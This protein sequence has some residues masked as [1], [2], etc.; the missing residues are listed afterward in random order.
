[1]KFKH[2]NSSTILKSTIQLVDL[3]SVLIAGYF[4]YYFKFNAYLLPVDYLGIVFAGIFVYL[5]AS[6]QLYRSWRGGGAFSIYKRMII[7][8]LI[9]INV[10][11]TALVVTKTAEHFSRVWFFYWS[12]FSIFQFTIYRFFIFKALAYM[13][14]RGINHKNILIIGHGKVQEE[15]VNRVKSSNWTGFDILDT[16]SLDNISQIE[17]YAKQSKMDE[18]WI[19]AGFQNNDSIQ[20]VISI[21]RLSTASI[22][23][24]P[25]ISDIGLLNKGQSSVLGLPALDISVSHMAGVSLI[26]KWIEDKCLSVAIIILIS[27]ILLII[28]AAIKLT[29]PGPAI[30]KQKRHGWNGKIITVYKFR[31][32]H[33]AD[34]NRP[35]VQ[36]SVG[37]SRVTPLG[38]FLR[39]SS[40]DELPQFFNVLLGDM[41]VVGPRPHAVEHNHEYMQRINSYM[42]RHKVKPGI[43]GWAQINGYRGET[44]TD[45]KMAARV[46]FDLYYIENW[47]LWLDLKIV[48]KTIPLGFF[49][50]NAY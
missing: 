10:I 28:A 42:L 9:V 16:I 30:F 35:V 22:R 50:K 32:M 40:L 49:H 15:I 41:S 20:S 18:V 1:M 25:D 27:P 37:D 14:K 3:I 45:Y 48:I 17:A 43:T 36:A 46:E 34:E 31:T 21:F 12:V 26:V 6:N 7:S 39:K 4:A 13:S 11:F 23:L 44:E 29:S 24:F 8:W 2:R 5:I 38:A 19:C 47:S 33:H